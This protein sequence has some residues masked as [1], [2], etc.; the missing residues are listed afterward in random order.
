MPAPRKCPDELR[1]R[2]TRMVVEARRNPATRPGAIARI[3][4]SS[5]LIARPCATG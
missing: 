4:T 1:E 2:A 3:A 5:A